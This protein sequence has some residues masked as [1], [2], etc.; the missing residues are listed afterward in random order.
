MIESCT[1]IHKIITLSLNKGKHIAVM[2]LIFII[3]AGEAFSQN[4]LHLQPIDVRN[5]RL[6]EYFSSNSLALSIG[7]E[8]TG[9]EEIGKLPYKISQ[10]GNTIP[11][12]YLENKLFFKFILENSLERDTVINFLPGFYIPELEIFK[13]PV[14]NPDSIYQITD[15]DGLLI[16]KNGHFPITLAAGE[17]SVIYAKFSFLRTNSNR[18]SPRLIQSHFITH[19]FRWR[20]SIYNDQDILSYLASGLLLLM[21]LYS[22]AVYI[23]NRG[24]EFI[25]YS[26]YAFFTGLLL[27]FKA[28]FQ[29]QHSQANF[30]FE[31]YLDLIILCVGIFFYFRF[32]RNF[33]N[34]ATRHP[35]LNNVIKYAEVALCILLMVYSYIYFFTDKYIILN[36]MENHVI[37]LMLLVIGIILII[38][39]LKKKDRL[40]K[41]IGLG[42]IALIFFSIVS[43]VLMT[44]RLQIFPS[45]PS[46][47]FNKSMFYYEVG[48]IL[49][50]AFFLMGL[51]W[52]NK[53][54]IIQQ[55][56]EK[57]SLKREKERQEYENRVTVLNAQQEE[58]D[59]ISADMHDELGSGVTAIR[60]M[61]EI[62]K[63][64]MKGSF[65]PEIDRIS[66][67]ANELLTKMNTIIW[68]MKSSNDSVESLTAYIRAYA[69]EY[70]DATPISCTVNF[71]MITDME[72][73]GEKR[74]NI[75]LSI[76]EALNNILKHSQA[77]K[78]QIDI[79]THNNK[80]IV[81]VHDNGIGIDEGNLRRFGNGLSNMRKRMKSLQGDFTIEN[82]GGTK[83]TFTVPL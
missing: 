83:L 65:L 29:L 78:V 75:F 5:I 30:F 82:D 43:L 50:L 9:I 27:F 48:L 12:R 37:K 79:I 7:S 39:S 42:N 68:T 69:I 15:E 72:M 57:E 22:L 21:I 47:L 40:L 10:S 11:G 4:E 20:K 31:E 56:K 55:V 45:R 17:A 25:Y 76:K 52:K 81:R 32:V 33:L 58:R 28:F 80:Y 67:S 41:Y 54:D 14:A 16:R 13:S 49:E 77:T 3:T 36:I 34:T 64:K 63:S 73:G 6:S 46:S 26:L 19:W 51:A 2:L 62:V 61:S 44:T 35:Q 38:H 18:I 59:R 70:F 60:L 71:S 1:L 24:K 66:N 74:R 8:E 53:T 23:Q